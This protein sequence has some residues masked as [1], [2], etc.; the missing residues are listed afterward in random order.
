MTVNAD[1]IDFWGA[2]GNGTDAVEVTVDGDVVWK[3]VADPDISGAGAGGFDPQGSLT[4]E[5]DAAYRGNLGFEVDGFSTPRSLP[6]SGG[7]LPRYPQPGDTVTIQTLSE[8]AGN[9]Y[10]D[11]RIF[12]DGNGTNLQ[13]EVNI[14][15]GYFRIRDSGTVLVSSDGTYNGFTVGN[16]YYWEADTADDGNSVT[17]RVYDDSDALLWDSGSVTLDNTQS[18]GGVRF[19]VAGG[20]GIAHFDEF[21][22]IGD[23]S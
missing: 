17:V 9:G 13:F 16:W 10:A 12:D 19:R 21:Q 7:T 14:S 11:W 22:V 18:Q 6:N 20:G 23:N 5:T 2:T 4:E 1:D 3:V 15:N 8:A